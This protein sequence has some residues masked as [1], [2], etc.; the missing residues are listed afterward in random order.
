MRRL[1]AGELGDGG[2]YVFIVP[3]VDTEEET[4]DIIEES[5]EFKDILQTDVKLSDDTTVLTLYISV[6]FLTDHLQPPLLP[7]LLQKHPLHCLAD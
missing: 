6:Y 3:T 5:E 7:P 1:W 4:E 2:R